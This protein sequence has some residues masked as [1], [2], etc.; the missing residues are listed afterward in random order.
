LYQHSCQQLS[1]LISL[2]KHTYHV[3]APL[4]AVVVVVVVNTLLSSA[5][6]HYPVFKTII[7]SR[8]VAL[9][10]S[11]KQSELGCPYEVCVPDHEGMFWQ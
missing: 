1:R 3:S 7:S 4:S 5:W 9:I 10:T 2:Q 11:S 6:N 8:L